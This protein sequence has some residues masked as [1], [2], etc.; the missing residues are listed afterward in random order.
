M[1]TARQS[2]RRTLL[3]FFVMAAAI[4][5]LWIAGLAALWLV[6]RMVGV[7]PEFWI[8][9]QGLTTMATMTAIL[10]GSIIGYRQL[11]LA[12]SSRHMAVADR[13]FA[14]LNSSENIEARRWIFQ[15]LPA[16]PVEGSRSLTPEGRSAVKLVLNSLDRVAF[17]TQAGWIPEEMI[18]PWMNPMVVKAWARLGPYVDYESRRRNEP[19]YYAEVRV[20]AEHCR[21]WRARN[22]L[23]AEITWTDNAL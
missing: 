18:M 23:E 22:L 19:D 15:N 14:E 13:L 6:V 11:T 7:A 3:R 9:A 12:T 2:S 4:F 17:L 8:M 16:D 10:S 21:I 5:S 1:K 20:L